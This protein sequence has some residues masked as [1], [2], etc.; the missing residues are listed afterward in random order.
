MY[1]LVTERPPLPVLPGPLFKPY[2][3]I[4]RDPEAV[5][6]DTLNRMLPA[7]PQR[8]IGRS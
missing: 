4:A 2:R 6:L 3:A 1:A 7:G 8:R 5:T